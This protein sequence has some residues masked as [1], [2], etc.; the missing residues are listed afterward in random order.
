MAG[1]SRAS[2]VLL[3][4]AL[5]ALATRAAGAFLRARPPGGPERWARTNYRGQTVSLLGGAAVATGSSA[6][7]LAGRA[8]ALAGVVAGAAA[9]GFGA[10]DDLT[11]SDEGRSKGFRGH[12]GALA[13]GK[14]TTGGA[15]LL[16]ISV[17][18]LAAA[19][20][21]TGGG[22]G[23][24]RLTRL[25]DVA[26][27]GALIA[28]T[29]NL[30]NLLDLRPGRALKGVVLLAAPVAASGSAGAPVAAAA[31]GAAISAL[32]DDLAERTMLGDTGANSLG[33]LAGT[34]L[35]LVPRPSVRG[36]V[37]AGVVTLTALSERVRFSQVIDRNPVLR[38]LD[39]WGRVHR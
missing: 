6:G 3:A 28:G 21:A 36:A 2:R 19:A 38:R 18:S 9:G 17:A 26:A 10:L 20:V 30:V 14:V 37:L 4:G 24:R 25:A 7:A 32:P 27:S 35:V 8:G 15:K 13:R 5:G 16:G 1:S 33:A 31:C 11:E 34:A 23:T 39:G 12:V 29:A 22:R